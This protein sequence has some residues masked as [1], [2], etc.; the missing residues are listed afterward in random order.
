MTRTAFVIPGD[1]TLPTGGYAYDR[2]VLALLADHGIDASHVVLPGS[3][4]SPGKDDLAET[5]RILSRL[6]DDT[7]LLID[8][9]A[10][11]AM[12]GDMIAALKHKIV[13]LVH[14]PLCLEAGLAPM[15]A[16]YLQQ[17]EQMALALAE[18]VVVT[19]PTTA[20]TLTADF[21]VPAAKITVAIP[22]TDRAPRARGTEEPLQLLAVG[23]VV[24]RKAY[25]VLAAALLR[26][27]ASIDW[28]LTIV[29]AV[30]DEAARGKLEAAL[31]AKGQSGAPLSEHVTLTGGVDDAQLATLY[32]RAD[33]FVM[34]SLYEGF[35]MV[36]TEAMARG[37]PIICTTG[38]AASETVPDVAAIKVLP[39]DA[40]ALGQAIS[41][42]LT[43]AELR[44]SLADASF[45]A[46]Q[47]LAT[48]DDAAR[49]VAAAL[50]KVSS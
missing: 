34:A 26:L 32:D 2:R 35:G 21:N 3:Y 49:L 36:L 12:P 15:R 45:A 44:R 13:A 28:H 22:G 16:R 39:G 9:L 48:W 29:G 10:Y 5:S 50:K 27:P 42:I 20:R 43:D 6:P 40:D 24:P 19:S 14:H 46:G 25:D 31:A 30:R 37:L 11:G 41:S 38:G 4:P 7:V 1:I 18:H 33:V 47:S 8:G 23:S 17:T